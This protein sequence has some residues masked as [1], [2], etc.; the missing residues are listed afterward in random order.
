M[1]RLGTVILMFA[2]LLGCNENPVRSFWNDIP[3]LEK[4][5]RV[6]E[7]RM[8]QFAEKAVRAPEVDALAAIDIL[9]NR[10]KDDEVAYY[11]YSEW[12]DGAFYNI[13]SPCRNATL[14]SKAVD[15]MA[16]DGIIS[17]SSLE[18]F[19]RKREW[20]QFNQ[21][22]LKATVP[23]CVIHERTLV[24]VLDTGC[25]TCREALTKLSAQPEWADVRRIAVCFGYGQEPT[26]PGWEYISDPQAS[27]VFDPKI[28]PVFFVVAA[29]GSVE[30]SY[31]L[32]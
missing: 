28:T 23:G 6:S 21:K 27:A 5:I 14:Y 13:L 22:G 32:L 24:L 10:L 7:D 29:D 2:F 17:S 15:R 19:Q 8:A 12:I 31:T 26:V 18:S 11:V 1:K 3:L 20:I 4:D 9:F 30:T 16:A 25:P